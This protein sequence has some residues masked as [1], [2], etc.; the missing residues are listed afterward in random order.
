MILE[1]AEEPALRVFR[2][3]SAT[4]AV[5]EGAAAATALAVVSG[6]TLAASLVTLA[7]VSGAVEAT[8]AAALARGGWMRPVEVD[9]SRIKGEG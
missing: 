8:A 7:V 3:A 1:K 9:N 6:A 2:V 5:G 4:A